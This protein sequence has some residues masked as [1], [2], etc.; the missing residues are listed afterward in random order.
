MS[1]CLSIRLFVRLY[2]ILFAIFQPTTFRKKDYLSRR[3]TAGFFDPKP[4]SSGI[5]V[6]LGPSQIKVFPYISSISEKQ[7]MFFNCYHK[8]IVKYKYFRK[9]FSLEAL[10]TAGRGSNLGFNY[11]HLEKQD[12]KLLTEVVT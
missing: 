1:V 8:V 6:K 3:R 2:P 9:S 10:K 11:S 12:K 5:V 7:A 4:N